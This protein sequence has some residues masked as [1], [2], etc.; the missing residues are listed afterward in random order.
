CALLGLDSLDE[1][2]ALL[3]RLRELDSLEAAE[4][5]FDRGVHLVAMHAGL[6]LPFE[7]L[8]PVLLLV[9]CAGP[10]DPLEELAAAL[11]G[12]PRVAV[13]VERAERERLWAYRERHTEA[14]NAF[15][16]PLKFDVAVRLP[17]LASTVHELE[18]DLEEAWP[19]AI[20]VLFGHLADGNMHINVLP[21][22]SGTPMLG[23]RAA[24]AEDVE[25]LVLRRVIDVGGAIS[26]EHGI[27]VAKRDWLVQSRHPSELAPMRA[28][29]RALDPGNLLNPGVLF[30]PD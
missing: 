23:S 19:D 25:A 20:V 11:E 9:E 29:K 16:V 15:G 17:E 5:M 24:T 6:P 7:P 18:G 12:L 2:V 27:G 4:V 28:I 1:A 26:A 3:P 8:P 14:I 22:E 13:A 10:R 30:P 21:P